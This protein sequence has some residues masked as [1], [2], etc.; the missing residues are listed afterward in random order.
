M[1]I[2][3]HVPQ[4]GKAEVRARIRRL[5]RHGAR[6]FALGF[7]ETIELHEQSRT[8]QRRRC[9]SAPRSRRHTFER[10]LTPHSRLAQRSYVNPYRR[11]NYRRP[12]D[13]RRAEPTAAADSGEAAGLRGTRAG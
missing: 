9:G 7:I 1:R 13:E 3:S 11:G 4:L 5:E 12:S 8:L 6:I 10:L 2:A